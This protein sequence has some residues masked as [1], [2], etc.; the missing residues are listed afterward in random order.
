[1]PIKVGGVT[2][3]E[4]AKEFKNIEL[5]RLYFNTNSGA[6]VH[7]SGFV[8]IDNSWYVLYTQNGNLLSRPVE[9]WFEKINNVERYKLF[10]Q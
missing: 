4:A 9:S 5:Y 7:V 3:D 10:I 6:I 2:L 8:T 1:M